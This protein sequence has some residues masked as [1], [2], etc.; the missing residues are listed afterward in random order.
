MIF[1]SLVPVILAIATGYAV[2]RSG[3]VPEPHWR[4]FEAVSYQVF[5][6][7]L[8]I[9]TL[10]AAD[11]R[12]TP[13]LAMGG[14]FILGNGILFAATLLLWPLL[15]RP[16]GVSGP[17]FTSVV[18][19]V[20]RW[21][22]FVA[23]AL[24]AALYGKQGLTAVALAVAVLTPIANIGSLWALGRWGSGV[25]PPTIGKALV[26]LIA[27]PF[28]WST[29]LGLG[30]SLLGIRFPNA[31]TLWIDMLGRAALGAG[32]LMVGAGLRLESLRRP[33]LTIIVASALKLVASPLLMAGIGAILGLSGVPLAVAIISTAVPTAAASYVLARQNGGDAEAMAAIVTAQTLLAGLTLPLALA[34]LV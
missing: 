25:K 13:W 8:M 15:L 21:N 10:A 7:A 14:T 12:E 18:Q 6:P 33:D 26:Q 17:A 31:V 20:I 30:I 2:R 32:L 27:N 11:I 5:F 23:I 29:L 19:G 4:G 22:S 9:A 16:H 24:S 3:L 28:M 1:D 34:W